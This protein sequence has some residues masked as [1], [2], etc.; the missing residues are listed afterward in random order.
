M[1]IKIDSSYNDKVINYLK[2]EREYNLTPINDI[3]KYGYDQMFFNVWAQVNS[4]GDIKAIILRYFNIITLY[5]YGECDIREI[6]NLIKYF[7]YTEITGKY[8]TLKQLQDYINFQKSRTVN[9]CKLDTEKFFDMMKNIENKGTKVKRVKYRNLNKIVK[10]YEAID[11]FENTTIE[12]IRYGLKSGRGYYIDDNKKIVSMAKSTSEGNGYA[13]VI[14]VGTDP[15]Y[16]N[17]GL[18]TKC[19]A[20]LCLDLINEGKIPCLLYDNEV[21]GK[22]YK[23]L[24]FEEIGK[25]SICYR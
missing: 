17:K 10:L 22:M 16:R 7:D 5:S 9:L 15:E 4:R 20:R 14:G 13:M 24:G 6:Y 23:K 2:R 8:S 3:N 25:W 19:M 12:N 11:E 18:A 21:A 1:L